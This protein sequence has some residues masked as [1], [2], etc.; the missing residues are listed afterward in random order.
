[1]FKG[2]VNAGQFGPI[3]TPILQYIMSYL[4]VISDNTTPQRSPVQI[5]EL[6]DFLNPANSPLQ[7]YMSGKGGKM[8]VIPGTL[9]TNF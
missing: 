5:T 8:Q 4:S 6:N 1:M 9:G 2:M 3:L 7:G